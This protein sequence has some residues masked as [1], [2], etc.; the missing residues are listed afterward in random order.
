MS[1]GP[2]NK[3]DAVRRRTPGEGLLGGDVGV[4]HLA[5]RQ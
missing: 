3:R 1:T 4:T 2:S 5:R